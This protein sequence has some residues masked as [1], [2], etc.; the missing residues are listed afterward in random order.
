MSQL[1]PPPPHPPSNRGVWG[2]WRMAHLYVRHPRRR[3]ESFVCVTWP[4]CMCAMTHLHVWLPR[5]VWGRSWMAHVHVRQGSFIRVTW[6]LRM[7]DMNLFFSFI[8]VT[9]SIMCVTWPILY[10][11]HDSFEVIC[12][13]YVFMRDVTYSYMWHARSYA[14]HDQFLS[15]SWLIWSDLSRICTYTWYD[16]FICVTCLN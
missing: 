8:R 3:H 1:L 5:G 2:R 9:C 12:L 15:V 4:L 16:S 7:R 6:R 11:C 10:M 14:W 13:E